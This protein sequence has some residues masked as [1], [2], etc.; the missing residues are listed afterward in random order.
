MRQPA[1][2]PIEEEFGIEGDAALGLG[3]ELHHPAVEAA[4]VETRGGRPPRRGGGKKKKAPPRRALPP[5]P[6][7]LISPPGGP[8]PSLPFLAP[9]WPARATIPPI[10]T[11]PVSLGLNGSDTS[12]CC[13]SPVPQHD[14]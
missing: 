11:L 13:R 9:G 4:V 12:Y 3:V 1:L 2:R 8:P 5:P 14:T 10:L 6:C 7:R